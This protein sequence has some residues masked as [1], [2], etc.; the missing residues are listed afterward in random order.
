MR[1]LGS[2]ILYLL[3][4]GLEDVWRQNHEGQAVNG[5]LNM[6]LT[7]SEVP[8]THHRDGLRR[9]LGLARI[10]GWLRTMFPKNSGLFCL[11][12][13][14][15]LSRLVMNQEALAT[16]RFKIRRA[17]NSRR[18]RAIRIHSEQFLG[19]V[20]AAALVQSSLLFDIV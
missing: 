17:L 4:K 18:L 14:K 1:F 15:V 3:F 9:F 6:R 12:R 11:D 16:K 5:L 19:A 10:P 13:A 8:S 20:L 7:K 2:W